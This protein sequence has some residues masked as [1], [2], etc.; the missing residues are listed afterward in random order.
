MKSNV[1]TR[2]LKLVFPSEEDL[3]YQN[4]AP[5]RTL[6]GITGAIMLEITQNDALKIMEISKPTIKRH[7]TLFQSSYAILKEFFLES[8][9]KKN[10]LG[11]K[12]FFDSKNEILDPKKMLEL[13]PVESHEKLFDYMYDLHFSNENKQLMDKVKQNI[14]K[15]NTSVDLKNMLKLAVKEYERK[16]SPAWLKGII[17]II[18]DVDAGKLKDAGLQ[19][20]G[21]CIYRI[22]LKKPQVELLRSKRVKLANFI[23]VCLKKYRE[24]LKHEI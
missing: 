23:E 13:I 22:E 12:Q 5:Y 19:K 14:D 3:I 10:T 21:S 1:T 15:M 9:Q 24:S 18:K 20:D 16:P 4:L 6:I 8:D 7:L 2:A 11:N 17:D